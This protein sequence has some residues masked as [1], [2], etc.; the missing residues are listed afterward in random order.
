ME[1]QE[2]LRG[3][4]ARAEGQCGCCHQRPAQVLYNR[5]N[6]PLGQVK[7]RDLLGVCTVCHNAAEKLINFQM[8]GGDPF[9]LLKDLKRRLQDSG[10]TSG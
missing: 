8:N 9:D 7:A 2:P 6:L 10:D 4:V 1:S 3:V 5:D